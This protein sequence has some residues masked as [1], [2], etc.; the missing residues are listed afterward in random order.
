[1]KEERLEDLSLSLAMVLLRRSKSL[2]ASQLAAAVRI[3]RNQSKAFEQGKRVVPRKVLER[4][5]VVAGF[6]PSLLEPL[7]RGI[8][9]FLI[10]GKGRSRADRVLS[11]GLAL[12]V[13][14]LAR[15][16]AD[17]TLIPR[18]KKSDRGWPAVARPRPEERT[19]AEPLLTFLRERCAP[20]DGRLLFEEAEEYR[21]WTVCEQAALLSVASAPNHPR[22][23]REWADLAVR[24]AEQVPGEETWRSRLHGWALYFLANAQR[25]CNDLPAAAESSARGRELWVAGRLMDPPGLLNEAWP[26]WIEACLMR[27]Q[28]RF[29]DALQT[30]D[31]ALALDRGE[32]RG[33]ILLSKARI[34]Q[35][36]GDPVSSTAV[37]LDA[38]PL[39]DARREP[40]LAL[41][42]R[43]NLLVD[44]CSLD[45]AAEAQLRLPGVRE[46]AEQ[47][48][49]EL[50]LT[51]C[52]WLA[53]KVETGLGNAAE[54]LAAFG[55]V[56]RDFRELE[57]A[58]DYAL[59]SLD[60]SL[61]LLDLGRARE[62]AAIA[63]EMLWI[64]KAQGV[65]REALAALGT[66]CEAARRE[67]ATA[68]L[69]QRVERFL[70]RARL[71]PALRFEVVR[72][73]GC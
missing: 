15:E 10:A 48:G 44:L 30:I 29:E 26:P 7:L 3:T 8:R 60:L 72:A 56:R 39:I 71:D 61:V 28:R 21:S 23:A 16:V 1:M 12:E 32:L 36:L 57:L 64:F 9:S 66:F 47:L 62:V 33:Q 50:D 54:A 42:L 49:E 59:V 67:I 13:L 53:G 6:R 20:A 31:E 5:A 70:R 25:A 55:R 51:R 38:E 52:A 34:Y 41:V 73:D 65:H 11:E 45:R 17:I 2:E 22:E 18:K 27:A 40:R 19:E 46:L 63:Q 43:F 58:Y 37:L 24:I 68:E 69:T 35:T 4:V 14:A